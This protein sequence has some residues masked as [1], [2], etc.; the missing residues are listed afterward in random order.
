MYSVLRFPASGHSELGKKTEKIHTLY[1]RE[2]NSE[3]DGVPL[4]PVTLRTGKYK[5]V[6]EID[7]P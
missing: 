4:D 2:F 7:H 1:S 3:S 6:L 5:S